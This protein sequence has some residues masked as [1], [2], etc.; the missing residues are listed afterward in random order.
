[1]DLLDSFLTALDDHIR[2]AEGFLELGL[3][4]LALAELAAMEEPAWQTHPRTLEMRA[5]IFRA[6]RDWPQMEAVC[7]QLCA[8]A[9]VNGRW[10]EMLALSVQRGKWDTGLS[11]L[12]VQAAM[13]QPEDPSSYY[14]LA[15]HALALGNL[16]EAA[17]RFAQ[18]VRLC[19]AFADLARGDSP[20]AALLSAAPP[21]AADAPSEQE[22]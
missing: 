5:W 9:E 16:A 4:R 14:L 12:Q 15:C 8:R 6:L 19:P 2:V 10:R 22:P 11:G 20:F 7:R 13:L 3:P 18:A 21:P 17:A 1:M